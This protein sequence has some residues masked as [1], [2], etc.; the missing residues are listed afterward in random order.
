ML[1]IST[2]SLLW[3][4]LHRV[5]WFVSKANYDWID[6]WLWDLNYDLWDEDYILSL[7]KEFNIPILSIT[8]P[9]F[10]IDRK[11]ID[12]IV[13]IALNT[14]AQ[15]ITFCPPH[16]TDKNKDWFFR[17]LPKIKKETNLS[18]C[19]KNVEAEFIMFV[20]PKH[21]NSNLED[22]KNITWDTTLDISAINNSSW[23]DILKTHHI[24]NDSIKNVMLSDKD[25]WNE[26]LIPWLSWWWISY[27]PLESFLMKLKTTG[28]NW[29]ITLNVNPTELWVWNEELVLQKL[30]NFK[31]YYKKYYLDFK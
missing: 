19:I 4:W 3:Y 18:I 1:L 2:S 12:K 21:K 28:Y 10:W 25:W 29:F 13:N 14:W 20:I 24:L 30:E 7:S 11:K 8:A 6:L 26:W 16:F 22:I 17:N 15:S 31:K 23:V 27:L 9:S 5:F